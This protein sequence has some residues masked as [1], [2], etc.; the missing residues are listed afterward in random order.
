MLTRTKEREKES[1]RERNCFTNIMKRR[2]R[3]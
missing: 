3:E 2:G 1:R